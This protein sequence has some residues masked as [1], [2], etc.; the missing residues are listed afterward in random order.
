MVAKTLVAII[1][2]I[3]IN[4]NAAAD[5]HYLFVVVMNANFNEAKCYVYRASITKWFLL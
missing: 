3:I 5:W 1:E 2:I 4:N